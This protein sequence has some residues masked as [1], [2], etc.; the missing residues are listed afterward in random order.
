MQ[1]KVTEL[2]LS[3]VSGVSI[4]N[5]YINTKTRRLDIFIRPTR[6]R[7]LNGPRRDISHQ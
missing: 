3:I 4:G 6:P 7:S 5:I 2:V 1:V